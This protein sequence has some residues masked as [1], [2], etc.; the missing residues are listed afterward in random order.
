MDN[1][2]TTLLQHKD[3]FMLTSLMPGLS[4]LNWN[5]NVGHVLDVALTALGLSRSKAGKELW[6]ATATEKLSYK[7]TRAANSRQ[8]KE[9]RQTAAGQLGDIDLSHDAAAPAAGSRAAQAAAEASRPPA[10]PQPLE[11]IKPDAGDRIGRIGSGWGNVPRAI[12]VCCVCELPCLDDLAARVQYHARTCPALLRRVHSTEPQWSCHSMG[13]VSVCRF[14]CDNGCVLNW[15]SSQRLPGPPAAAAPA[16]PAAPAVPAA[17]A[18]PAVPAAPTAPAAPTTTAHADA[19]PTDAAPAAAAPTD[20]A[21]AAAAPTDAAPAA[22][23]PPLDSATVKRALER[24]LAHVKRERTVFSMT[25]AAGEMG[26][27]RDTLLRYLRGES[28]P[29]QTALRAMA[30]WERLHAAPPALTQADGLKPSDYVLNLRV[31]QL[32]QSSVWPL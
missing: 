1:V 30:G 3:H 26:V 19:A 12:S 23:A 22:A 13:V 10:A 31:P 18:A 8:P 24:T 5:S 15:A 32:V 29:Q 21:P 2:V 14:T 25:V 27:G 7:E 20:A 9:Q 4:K 6:T 17:P 11:L 16:A 28:R